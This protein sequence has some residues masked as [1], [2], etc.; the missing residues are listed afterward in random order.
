VQYKGSGLGIKPAYEPIILIQK[1]L[2][3]NYQLLK[4]LLNMEQG[5]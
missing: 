3:K 2:E 4:T 5:H 1:P